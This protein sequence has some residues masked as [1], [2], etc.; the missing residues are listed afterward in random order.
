MNDQSDAQI[1]RS[2]MYF[3]MFEK[4]LYL[5]QPHLHAWTSFFIMVYKIK[6]GDSDPA[7]EVNCHDSNSDQNMPIKPARVSKT[8]RQKTTE[9]RKEKSRGSPLECRFKLP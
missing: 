7:K 6:I 5:M 4:G 8:D 2:W 3:A 9:E 1:D